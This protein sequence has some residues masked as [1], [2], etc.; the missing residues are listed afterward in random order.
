MLLN[1]ESLCKSF[2]GVTAVMDVSLSVEK[3][4]L[5]SIIGPNGAGK[6]T[7]FNLLT[8]HISVDSGNIYFKDRKITKLQPHSI[9]RIGIGRSFQR[10]S[11]FPRLSVFENV[12]VGI[13]SRERKSYKMLWPAR[14][15]V[16][17]E[18][19]EILEAIGLAHQAGNLAATLP[20]G[21]QKRLELGITLA[22]GPE[23][24]LLDEPTA[25]MSPEERFSIIELI[26]NLVKERG[27]T[28]L[29]T[30]HDM[31]IVF[32]ISERVTV[33]HQG[34]VIAEGS[35]DEIRTNPE[36]QSVYLGEAEWETTLT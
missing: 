32:S 27:L 12:H 31:D 26:G 30:E 14:R 6:T 1:V 29:F 35:P 2:G 34:K 20:H 16:R 3:G 18:T 4:D 25:G 36:V 9:A 11:I 28:L 7:L 5:R 23:L 13:L 17:T 10:I 21:D 15:M 19:L 8:G 24:L 22:L 33:L